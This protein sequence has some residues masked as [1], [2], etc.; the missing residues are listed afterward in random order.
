MKRQFIPVG[1]SFAQWKKD[2]GYAAAYASLE[3]E[4]AD[5]EEGL[6]QG[7]ED[8]AEGRTRPAREVFAEFRAKHRI[9]R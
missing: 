1:E 7:L 3:E 8:I 4:V 2:P 6:H 5:L 9:A